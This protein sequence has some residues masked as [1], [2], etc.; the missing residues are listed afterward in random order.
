MKMKV[1]GIKKCIYHLFLREFS[2]K[3][4]WLKDTGLRDTERE[5]AYRQSE[6]AWDLYLSKEL[7]Y[8]PSRGLDHKGS[9]DFT[10]VLV[11][12]G[13]VSNPV[14]PIPLKYVVYKF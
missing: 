6:H 8:D 9:Y 5:G 14:S 4:F 7:M 1:V 13:L 10:S 11:K 2:E 12:R 3:I